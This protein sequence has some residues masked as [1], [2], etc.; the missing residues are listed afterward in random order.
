MRS[1]ILLTCL[2]VWGGP[3]PLKKLPTDPQTLVTWL[4][5]ADPARRAAAFTLF[6]IPPNYERPKNVELHFLQLDEDPEYEATISLRNTGAALLMDKRGPIWFGAVV[7]VGETGLGGD[8]RL[9]SRRLTNDKY[10]DLLVFTEGR[11]ETGTTVSLQVLTL[12]PAGFHI[13]HHAVLYDIEWDGFTGAETEQLGQVEMKGHLGAL[14]LLD[15]FGKHKCEAFAWNPAIVKFVP[16]A[17]ATR[18][19][20]KP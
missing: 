9:S 14:V 19:L 8:L 3:L 4:T 1:V 6:R 17:D 7:E 2:T 15:R 13:A 16:N 10:E 11:S 12:R 5:S 18:A 20:C